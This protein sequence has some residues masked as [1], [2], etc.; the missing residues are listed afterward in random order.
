MTK[1]LTSILIVGGGTAGWITAA[2]IAAKHRMRCSQDDAPSI[3]VSLI[4][5]PDIPTIGVGEGTWPG[6]R[7][8]LK[9]IGIKES[10]FLKECS[11]SFKQGSM[12]VGWRNGQPDDYY[13]HP[14]E[15]PQGY[16]EG[17]L[18]QYWVDAKPNMSFSKMACVQESICE[19]NLSPK[20]RSSGDYAGVVNYGYHLDA[21]KF[22]E[23]LKRHCIEKLG[24]QLVSDKVVAVVESAC[25]DIDSVKTARSGNLTADLFVDCSGF[26]SLLL[27]EHFNIEFI[28]KSDA[29]PINS[30]LAVQ[31]PY[32]GEEAIKSVTVSTAQEAGWIWDIGLSSRR[33]VGYVFSDKYITKDQA[34]SQ[35]QSYLGLADEKFSELSKRSI[36]IKPGYR[37]KFWHKNCV[38]VGLSAGFLEPLEASAIMLIEVSAN[39]IADQMPVNRTAMDTVAKRFNRRTRYRWERIIDFLKL[40]YT[41]SER[42]EPFWR[43]SS[44]DS[45]LSERLIEDLALWRHQTPWKVD[46]DSVDEVFPVA[47]YQYVLYGM[48]FET[49]PSAR[50]PAAGFV[51]FS[52]K[53]LGDVQR[54]SGLLLPKVET[55]RVMLGLNNAVTST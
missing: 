25:G 17:N 48:G 42:P 26:K 18:S 8:T 33:G 22:S 13:Y 27:A 54:A 2:I 5:A 35:L 49:L 45:S 50:A 43:D 38:A 47:S 39:M 29:F 12:F 37:E 31:L 53:A 10:D 23:F 24:V 3:Q 19:K 28:D 40:H 21:G 20:L 9:K 6:M 32:E 46:F 4:E 52:Q 11:A 30:A 36:P 44:C 34:A 14:F 7:S 1:S 51:E 15:M 41:L 55:N 16:M